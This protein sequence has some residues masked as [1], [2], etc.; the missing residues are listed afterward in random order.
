[1]PQSQPAAG[2]GGAI[3]RLRNGRNVIGLKGEMD[4]EARRMTVT[5]RLEGK[6][7]AEKWPE[8]SGLSVENNDLSDEISKRLIRKDACPTRQRLQ[9]NS[10]IL[11]WGSQCLPNSLRSAG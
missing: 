1:M 7:E 10:K 6:Q 8:K 2:C 5:R 11:L 9:C 3:T 4:G